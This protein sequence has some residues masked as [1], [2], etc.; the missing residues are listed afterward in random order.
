MHRGATQLSPTHTSQSQLLLL[1]PKLK[2]EDDSQFWSRARLRLSIPFRPH[3]YPS[4]RWHHHHPYITYEPG[5][6][7]GD[8]LALGT[9]MGGR[10]ST[11]PGAVAC[12]VRALPYADPQETAE[13]THI[14]RSFL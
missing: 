1:V 13:G 12:L 6:K 10:V 9:A 8:D 5:R 14:L 4:S 11:C 3:D 2:W 7:A